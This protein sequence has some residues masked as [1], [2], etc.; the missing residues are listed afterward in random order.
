MLSNYFSLLN[1]VVK[2]YHAFFKNIIFIEIT[3]KKTFNDDGDGDDS[4]AINDNYF[5]HEKQQKLKPYL[6]FKNDFKPFKIDDILNSYDTLESKEVKSHSLNKFHD[7]YPL[8][9]G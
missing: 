1:V 8:N 9:Y 5:N 6:F 4:E 2:F 7:N 3:T